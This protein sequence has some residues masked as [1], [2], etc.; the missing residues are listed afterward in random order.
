MV[1]FIM[2]NAGNILISLL[3]IV[4]VSCAVR[5]LIKDKRQGRSSCG[6]NCAHCNM[7]AGGRRSDNSK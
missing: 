1:S 5:T 6:G 7:C 2:T 4:I 3:L